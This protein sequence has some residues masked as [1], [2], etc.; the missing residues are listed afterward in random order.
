M[1]RGGDFVGM[2][3]NVDQWSETARVTD[4]FGC[5]DHVIN[6]T[7]TDEE[8]LYLP[9]YSP[10]LNPIEHFG[11]RLKKHLSKRLQDAEDAFQLICDV[12]NFFCLNCTNVE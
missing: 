6:R 5:A 4:V 3:D 1:P 12:C 10:D 7:Y 2:L 11:S 8:L 9:S